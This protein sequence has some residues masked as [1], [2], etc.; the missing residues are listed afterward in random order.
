MKSDFPFLSLRPIYPLY[1]EYFFNDGDTKTVLENAMIK[2]GKIS[3]F[4]EGC[5]KVVECGVEI[6]AVFKKGNDFYAIDNSC[7]HRGGPLGESELD[8]VYVTCPWHAWRFDV[9]TGECP[10]IPGEKIKT[11]TCHIKDDELFLEVSVPT[12]V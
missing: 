9:V 11:Y 8:G 2:V 12:P 7:S 5:A 1:K 10:D 3:E 6:I 4:K